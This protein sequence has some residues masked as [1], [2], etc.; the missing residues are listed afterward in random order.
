MGRSL[1][2]MARFK[3]EILM[4]HKGAA[5]IVPF[6]PEEVWGIAPSK[7]S[8]VPGGKQGFLVRG[9]LAGTRFQGW[10]GQRWGRR[11]VLTDGELLEKSGAKV[12]DTVELV[13]EPRAK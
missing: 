8:D 5:V 12:G 10:I 1:K 4:G 9:T 7:V 3:A 6:D 2:K 11:F 13:L